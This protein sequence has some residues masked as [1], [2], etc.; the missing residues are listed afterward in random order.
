MPPNVKWPIRNGRPCEFI[1]QINLN[2]ASDLLP[3]E[4]LLLFFY[5]GREYEDKEYKPYQTGI[6]T[7]VYYTGNMTSL[8]RAANFPNLLDELQ[9]YRACTISF[10]ANWM[11]P[12]GST[13]T[14]IVLERA[15]FGRAGVYEPPTPLAE[16]YRQV[17]RLLEP[18]EDRDK[19]HLF[20][21]AEPIIQDDPFYRV[22]GIWDGRKLDE[23]V[24]ARWLLLLQ[25]SS[26]DGPGML[27][28]DTSSLYYCIR[29]DDLVASR[30]ENALCFMD[31]H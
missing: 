31:S 17:T 13:A 11:P 19:H 5:D 15:L 26:D 23:E 24:L 7:I 2:D 16:A 14:S 22:P 21:Y 28:G 4:G 6:E 18:Y 30:F 1:A 29:K 9:R 8:R 10:E 27:W 3:K 20:G 12:N 25:I